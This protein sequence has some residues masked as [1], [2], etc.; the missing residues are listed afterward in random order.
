M[1]KQFY[2][3]GLLVFLGLT[4]FAQTPTWEK[5]IA[6]DASLQTTGFANDGSRV[7]VKDS[8]FMTPSM[9]IAKL[10][11]KINAD[12]SFAWSV[13]FKGKDLISGI[14]ANKIMI[15]AAG[16]TYIAGRVKGTVYY[17]TD[18]LQSTVS[19][20]ANIFLAKFNSTGEMTWK[21]QS[22]H[23]NPTFAQDDEAFD[24]V[25]KG[26]N[27]Y[28]SGNAKGRSIVIGS[29]TFPQMTNNSIN[30]LFIAKFDTDG[31]YKWSVLTKDGSA[32]SG[33]ID[34]DDAGNVYVGGS[35]T[36]NG[37]IQFGN[38]VT[39]TTFDNCHFYAKINTDG[40]AQAAKI[41][42]VGRSSSEFKSLS[43]DGTGNI[44]VTGFNDV[45]S[46]V[47]SITV[48]ANVGYVMKLDNTGAHQWT[49][50]M[51]ANLKTNG[52]KNA[53]F[54]GGKLYFTATPITNMHIQSS[55][56]DSVSKN[57]SGMI[58]GAYLPDGNLD[59]NEQGTVTGTFVSSTAI[60]METTEDKSS[61]YYG[62]TF[63]QGEKFGTLTLPTPG[64]V[65]A[66]HN[67]FIQLKIGG[68]GNPTS[69]FETQNTI[70]VKVYPNPAQNYLHI[71]LNETVTNGQVE[72]LNMTGQVM[73][74][75]ELKNTSTASI[76]DLQFPHGMYFV[77]VTTVD[78]SVLRK[79]II[80]N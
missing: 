75:K 22:S 18:S 30:K 71:E 44:Y 58:A 79:I 67:G 40:V 7:V 27:I 42:V 46:D 49:R 4:S 24:A 64:V 54:V 31:D 77:K 52:V 76:H 78:G 63:I 35:T 5:Y 47:N 34:V 20:A 57:G 3:T 61:V 69:L 41:F 6:S 66:Y 68:G 28:V 33:G 36:G 16:N 73:Y 11:R 51:N 19:T 74:A 80:N 60:Q 65:G 53:M 25:L 32:Y 29:D 21:W 13:L 48:R 1:K 70:D 15:D 45:L 10:V 38:S 72:I 2:L 50:V 14:T 23:T 17:G 12:G 62:G 56:T 37:N 8:L 59:W 43:V 55:A 9:V 39:I 26:S